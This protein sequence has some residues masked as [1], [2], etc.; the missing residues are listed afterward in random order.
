MSDFGD[1]LAGELARSVYAPSSVPYTLT[2][3]DHSDLQQKAALF[4]DITQA[5]PTSLGIEVSRQELEA[6]HLT[7]NMSLTYG[8]IGQCYAEFS[9]LGEVFKAIEGQF[10]GLG[11]GKFY[12]LG[13]VLGM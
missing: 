5:F 11:T 7:T 2:P 4:H 10:G 3:S 8:E 13:A 9:A 1:F 12:D 6:K